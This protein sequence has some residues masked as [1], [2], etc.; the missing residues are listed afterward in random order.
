MRR[1]LAVTVIAV[2]ALAACSGGEKD[3]GEE[4]PKASCGAAPA[5][6]GSVVTQLPDNFPT[7]EGV[8]YTGSSEAGPSTVIEAYFAGDLDKAYE[9]Y[10]KELHDAGFDVTSSEKEEDD[11]EVN[12]S[13]GNSTG[14]VK[15][16]ESCQGR[17]D[18]TITARPA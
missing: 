10:Q 17:T 2:L 1:L 18:L 6:N 11:A 15:M 13:G 8:T 14:Q 5:S 16:V 12:F 3:Q 4:G 9:S 7:P